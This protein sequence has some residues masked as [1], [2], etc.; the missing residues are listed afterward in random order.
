MSWFQ[1]LSIRKRLPVAFAL[2]ALLLAITGFVGVFGIS[3]I[4]P[5]VTEIYADRLLPV[6]Q[7]NHISR[8]W[9]VVR[10]ALLRAISIE[11][12][13]EEELR[14]METRFAV[15]DSLLTTYEKHQLSSQDKVV[16]AD[17]KNIAARYQELRGGVEELIRVGQKAEALVLV[18]AEARVVFGQMMGI[19]ESMIE[20][21]LH[22]AAAHSQN[23]Q[24]TAQT[25]DITMLS[26]LAVAV[27]LAALFGV[28]ITRSIVKPLSELDGA[29]RKVADGDLDTIVKA[30][31]ADE[32]GSLAISFNAMVGAV[33]SGMREIEL[34]SA[35]ADR[36]AREAQQALEDITMLA[37]EVRLA[38]DEVTQYT[39]EISSSVQ[40]MAAAVEEQA[41]QA[42]EVAAASEEMAQTISE[43]A[44]SITV[45]AQ[46]STQASEA[47][48]SGSAAV[49]SARS[50]MQ[51][52]ADVTNETGKKI[53]ALTSKVEEVGSISET[54]TDIADQTNLLALN[55]AI[56]A[57][58]AGTH[59][60]GF[61][62][63]A[64]EVRKLAERTAKATKDIAVVLKSIQQETREAHE[65]MERA[66]TVVIRELSSSDVLVE[67]FERISRETDQVT[68][69]VNQIAVASEEQ[70]STMSEVSRSI[71]GMHVVAE[72]SAAGVHQIAQATNHLND[73]AMGLR[74][75]VNRFSSDSEGVEHEN[76]TPSFGANGVHGKARQG[77]LPTRRLQ[78]A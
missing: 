39:T 76:E 27:V 24:Q 26:V 63:V 2:I 73:L 49:Q 62:V 70:S 68:T 5:I 61:A 6:N 15:I 11:G 46:S 33:R 40:Q 52:I 22:S 64:D 59:G 20:A 58:R 31:T 1:N 38:T 19:I 44:Q 7:L 72:E 50:S 54:I 4:T 53:D 34:K 48:R 9:Y 35:E 12:A 18:N 78:M 45:T 14:K 60:R 47:S 29:A 25:V 28:V 16:L 30:T 69:L 42:A 66:G 17:Y 37:N 21:E 65:S 41:Q 57:A 51:T 74:S 13:E 56:E 8:E 10:L 43:T 77:V 36:S 23:A 67:A 55:A 3:T 32:L 75:M 71:E